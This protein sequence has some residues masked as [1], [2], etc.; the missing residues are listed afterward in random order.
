LFCEV[1][2][3]SS[4]VLTFRLMIV[5]GISVSLAQDRSGVLDDNPEP[6][7]R[8]ANEVRTYGRLGWRV[9][10]STPQPE[11]W[12]WSDSRTAHAAEDLAQP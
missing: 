2:A 5:V 3:F 9:N 10:G 11:R 7:S 4:T 6:C 8:W 12:L 1:T